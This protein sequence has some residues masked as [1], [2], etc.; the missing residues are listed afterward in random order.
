M[1]SCG[2]SGL[3]VTAILV[4]EPRITG[5]VFAMFMLVN[6]PTSV[7]IPGT[8]TASTA[9]ARFTNLLGTQYRLVPSDVDSNGDTVDDQGRTL[10]SSSTAGIPPAPVERIRFDCAGPTVT[11]AGFSCVIDQPSDSSG[12]IFPPE[13]AD[14]IT[15]RLE[16]APAQ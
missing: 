3:D 13:V 6:Y 7:S 1:V 15:C 5:D 8:G 12:Q 2:P 14:L 9:R 16:L 11:T 10:V 4:Y